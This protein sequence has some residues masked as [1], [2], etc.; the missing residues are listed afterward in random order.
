MRTILKII[1]TL[2]L[3]WVCAISPIHAQEIDSLPETVSPDTFSISLPRG[4]N[5]FAKDTTELELVRFSH[6]YEFIPEYEEETIKQRLSQI[7]NEI[8]LTYN[9]I[10]NSFISYFTVTDRDYTR[11]VAR[12]QTKYFP[13]IERYLKKY[14]LPDE[15]KYLAIVESG[16][17]PKAKSPAGAVGLWQFMP[18]TGRVD[19]GLSENWYL[20]EKMDMEKSTDAACRY[21]TF[22]Y[23]YFYNDWPLA[24]AAYNTGPGN[25]RKA[26]RRS[27]YKKNFWEIYPYL[28][29]ET[30]SYVP[31]FIAIMYSMN[32][33]EEHNFFIEEFE[34]M[35][36]YEMVSINSFLS[37][38]LFAEHSGICLE[39]LNDLNP[40][41]KRGVV[42]DNHHMYQ[43]RIPADQ[44]DFISEN[45]D[46]IMRFASQGEEHF[47]R[48]AKNEVG[49][50]YGRQK[51]TYKVRSG[52]VLG[53]IAETYKVRIADLKQWNNISGTV[54]RVGQP[55]NIWIADDFYD[56]VNK[57]LTAISQQGVSNQNVAL[58]TGEYRVQNGD[59][60]WE[61]SRKFEGLTVEKLK[62]LNNLEGNGIKPGQILK[63]N[64][65]S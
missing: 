1:L 36:D 61:I 3:Y 53:K 26:I 27:G 34:Y 52:D 22:L 41:L 19:Y 23:K 57:K 32:Y 46:E 58:K 30:R 17:N 56:D 45:M 49:S 2:G 11:K 42:S 13:M 20:D 40:E 63:I 51:L 4:F 5:F 37:L 16:L 48:L 15:L 54:I 47:N 9:P 38:P 24:L 14:N 62:K 10:V 55:L 50:T 7:E 18:L 60:L 6:Q 64:E 33:L 8:P 25:V 28:Y 21:L 35:P 65:N 29:R 31:Q 39:T 43:L 12:L 44:K 59:T